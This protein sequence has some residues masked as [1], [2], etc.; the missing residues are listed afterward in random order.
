MLRKQTIIHLN[1]F[2]LWPLVF[3]RQREDHWVVL[4][5]MAA[6]YVHWHNRRAVKRGFT[7]SQTWDWYQKADIQSWKRSFSQ[8]FLQSC[9]KPRTPYCFHGNKRVSSSSQSN[10]LNWSSA[11]LSTSIKG[12]AVYWCVLLIVINVTLLPRNCPS[13]F[14][15]M[16]Y[17]AVAEKLLESNISD[18]AGLR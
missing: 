1:I 2:L 10:A 16:L 9:E 4:R 7:T 13:K 3:Y 17:C 15:L 5:T 18:S 14:N 8:E 12:L 6:C 11:T